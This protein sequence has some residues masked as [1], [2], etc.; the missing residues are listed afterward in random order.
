MYEII[1]KENIT[2]ASWPEY[3]GAYLE[4]EE[5]NLPVQI[6]GKLKKTIYVNKTSEEKTVIEAI[7]KQ[8]PELITGDIIK[9][10]YV[11]GKIINIICK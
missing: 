3:D 5:I 10:I 7:K 11:P 6:N 9:V 1:F 8:M 2:D 4:K